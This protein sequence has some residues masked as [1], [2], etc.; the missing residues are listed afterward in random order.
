VVQHTDTFDNVKFLPK[1]IGLKQIALQEL[2]MVR[3]NWRALQ[4]AYARLLKLKSI[5]I[6][7]ELR[8]VAAAL[9]A[10]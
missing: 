6:T 10:C 8:Y 9:T 7:L 5:A 4:A 2:E 3:L 1:P